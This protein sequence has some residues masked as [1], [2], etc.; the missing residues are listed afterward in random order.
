[1]TSRVDHEQWRGPGGVSCSRMHGGSWRR[2]AGK[3]LVWLSTPRPRPPGSSG[4]TAASPSVS[5][6]SA[7]TTSNVLRPSLPSGHF[8]FFLLLFYFPPFP[9]VRELKN[10]FTAPGK[11]ITFL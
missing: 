9:H 2:P 1:L 6:D 4:C 11:I 10:V 8:F 5:H 3:F 7:A